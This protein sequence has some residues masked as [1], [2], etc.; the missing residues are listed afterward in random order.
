[1][2]TRTA[3]QTARRLRALLLAC[4][5]LGV[6]ALV[7]SLSPRTSAGRPVLGPD[8]PS[9]SARPVAR[10]I[11]TRRSVGPLVGRSAP[12]FSF[13]AFGGDTVDLASLRGKIVVLNFFASWCPSCERELA[14]LAGLSA[15]I[16]DYGRVVAVAVRDDPDDA[17]DLVERTGGDAIKAGVDD[18]GSIARAYSILGAPGT[19]VIGPDGRVAGDWRGPIGLP[20]L[21]SFLRDTFPQTQTG[22]TQRGG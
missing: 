11:I 9:S 1:M 13:K 7:M 18:D 5:L 4:L 10:E 19:V 3:T 14:Q 17:K 8:A 6:P 15:V 12:P 20:M 22:R 21:Y 2:D 16:Y